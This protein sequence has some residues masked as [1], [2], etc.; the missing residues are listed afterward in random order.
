M[1]LRKLLKDFATADI[2]RRLP[3]LG[4]PTLNPRWW[5][6]SECITAFLLISFSFVFVLAVL[7]P[8]NAH[9]D[10]YLHASVAHYYRNH[11][12]PPR[13]GDPE[14]LNTYSKY[15]TSYINEPGVEY[16]LMGKFARFVEPLTGSETTAIRL[17]NVCLYLILV[18]LAIV[19]IKM[20]NRFALLF[21]PLILTPQIWYVF[22]YINNDGFAFF[23]MMLVALEVTGAIGT[24]DTFAKTQKNLRWLWPAFRFG[25][26]LGLMLIAKKNY[27]FFLLFLGLFLFVH[28]IAHVLEKE[29]GWSVKKF[30]LFLESRQFIIKKSLF[31]I[32][33]ASSVTGVRY[34]Y[35]I[36]L[37]GFAGA[38]KVSA[39]KERLADIG[40]RD[41]TLLHNQSHAYFGF[42]L[43]SR[44]IKFGQLFSQWH[45]GEITFRSFVGVYGWMMFF[46][47]EAYYMLMKF[48]YLVLVLLVIGDALLAK[49]PT[50]IMLIIIL[51]AAGAATIIG[52]AYHSWVNDFQAQGR[53]LFTI[54]GMLGIV[55]YTVDTNRIRRL[56]LPLAVCI[57]SLSVYSFIFVAMQNLIR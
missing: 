38:Q 9:P 44:G 56:L 50:G 40:F 6:F 35:D 42:K 30:R 31:I 14:T 26:F 8:F 23:L 20:D 25:V 54:T 3:F 2:S 46:S 52:S 37:N 7:T 27:Y 17:F 49:N 15:G 11:W 16:V 13:I 28:F 12:L 41:S 36:S 47:P 39:L 10:E 34:T 22:S 29:T 21:L 24:P 19:R 45:W 48:L 18:V 32:L 55:L 33:I 57:F 43:K 53:Y 1:V 51:L 4:I 5:V